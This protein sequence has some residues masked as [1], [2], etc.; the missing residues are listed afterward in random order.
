M[1]TNKANEMELL[2]KALA[3]RTRL[4]LL[5]LLG[6]DEVCVCYFVEVLRTNQPKISRHLAY[7][8]RAGVVTARREGKWMH[9]R[10]V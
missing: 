1:A 2:F 4:R 8:R 3:D 9:Y 5:N 10:I 6:G 7:L